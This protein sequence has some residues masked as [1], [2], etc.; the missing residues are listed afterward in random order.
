MSD[1][2]GALRLLSPGFPTPSSPA[3]SHWAHTTHE[4]EPRVVLRFP[5][6][7]RVSHNRCPP[8]LPPSCRA[9]PKSDSFQ[10]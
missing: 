5:A 4:L 6:R 1:R 8:L 10:S 7:R 9:L 3:P 2:S